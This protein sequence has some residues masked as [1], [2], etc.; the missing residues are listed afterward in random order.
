[1]ARWPGP[2]YRRDRAPW[3][4]LGAHLC[5]LLRWLVGSEPL[6]VSARVTTFGTPAEFP[7]T[8]MA[9]FAFASG[10]LARVWLTFELPEPGLG[11]QV[12]FTIVGS[13]G[14]L[15]L[16]SYALARLGTK[17][18]WRVLA[19]QPQG[20]PDDPFD[21]ARLQSYAD[22]MRDFVEAVAARREPLVDGQAGRTTIAMLEAAIRSDRERR[23]V[24]IAPAPRRDPDV[25]PES[26]S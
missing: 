18:G 15:E 13:E 24:E 9:T 23:T 1:M 7:Q 12:E 14:M 19:E 5:D 25:S 4:E 21:P 11:S 8:V 20:N 3:V 10:V 16:D 22:Q 6:D 2:A 26:R 17:D